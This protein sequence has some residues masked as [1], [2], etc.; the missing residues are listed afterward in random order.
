MYKVVFFF[1]FVSLFI[2]SQNKRFVYEYVFA[3]D[4]THL[5]NKEKEILNLDIGKEGSKFYAAQVL[6]LDSLIKNKETPM[7]DFPYQKIGFLDVVVKKY[8]S[9][10]MNFYTSCLVDYNVSLHKK[11]DWQVFPEKKNIL[12]YSVQRATTT[13]YKRKWTV[14]FTTD[15]PVQDGPYLFQGLPGL[16]IKAEDDQRSISFNLIGIQSLHRFDISEIPYY[17]KSDLLQISEKDLKNAIKNFHDK[18]SVQMHDE[19]D[20]RALNIQNFHIDGKEVSR[21]E[22]YRIMEQNNKEAIKK[23]NNL[24]NYDII[25]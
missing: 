15:I 17:F 2:K 12:G 13:L 25:K 18:P 24:L 14:W 6:V 21:S 11:L 8:P 5:E 4:S 22:F 9:F 16:I 3:K 1:L 19:G 7:G 10:D 20:P 23:T